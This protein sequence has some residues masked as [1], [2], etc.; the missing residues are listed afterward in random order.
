M[1]SWMKLC[2]LVL[3]L[4]GWTQ[5]RA[6]EVGEEAPDIEFRES[7]QDTKTSSLLKDAKNR[8]QVLVF[9]R[10]IDPGSVELLSKLNDLHEK[11][12]RRGVRILALTDEK[13]EKV[14]RITKA[15][16]L[17]ISQ[18]WEV[19]P[20]APYRFPAPSYAYIIDPNGR[21]AYARFHAE[22][23]LEG[24]IKEVI[25]RTP[26]LGSDPESLQKRMVRMQE[27]LTKG[28]LGRAYTLA[29]E[30]EAS[31]EDGDADTRKQIAELLKQIEEGGQNWLKE[32]REDIEA[33]KYQK[34]SEKLATISV[35]FVGSELKSEADREL[36]RLQGDNYT[37]GIAR[38]AIDNAK[39]ELR[40]DDALDLEGLSP[41]Q[42]LAAREIYTQVIDEY[43]GTDAAKDAQKA[44]DRISSDPAVRREIEAYQATQQANRWYD[45]GERFARVGMYDL[46]RENFE[47]VISDYPKEE[48]AERARERL[49]SLA[50]EERQ[51][52]R[53]AEE[54]A[55][56]MAS[57]E[58]SGEKD[59]EKK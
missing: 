58:T 34:A 47:K 6:Q 18:A 49:T 25:R 53:E 15:K 32:A 42:Y 43:E 9:W 5:A 22:D 10:T 8:I 48:A 2:V 24:K 33:K 31:L 56:R 36:G 13:K 40:I 1:R 28:E 50:R 55:K 20:E 46:A 4:A 54:R 16:E 52:Q 23:D 51:A 45:L 38:K 57:K 44:I 37:K 59:K 21:I 12:Y 30:L 11:Y 41:P 3:L 27:F 7:E 17:K 19:D 14:E 35:R 39:G 29:K 26:P